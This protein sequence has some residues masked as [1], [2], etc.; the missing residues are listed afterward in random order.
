MNAQN[1]CETFFGTASLFVDG[2]NVNSLVI[3]DFTIPTTR[4][5]L[6]ALLL[7]WL[8]ISVFTQLFLV[9]DLDAHAVYLLNFPD[10]V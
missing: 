2:R 9:L 5:F 3:T 4:F 7:L 6:P 10:F 1:I 8:H